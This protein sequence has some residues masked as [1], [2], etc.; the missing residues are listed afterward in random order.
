MLSFLTIFLT[1]VILILVSIYRMDE[2]VI[3]MCKDEMLLEQCKFQKDMVG[4]PM[5]SFQLM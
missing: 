3:V 5:A 4:S 1:I 2:I